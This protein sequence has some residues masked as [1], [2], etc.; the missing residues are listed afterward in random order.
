NTTSVT[1]NGPYTV[2]RGTAST[3]PNAT[4]TLNGPLVLA[5]NPGAFNGSSAV[6]ATFNVGNGTGGTVNYL[7]N[8]PISF[9]AQQTGSSSGFLGSRLNINAGLLTLGTSINQDANVIATA[10]A[11]GTAQLTFQ[12]GATLR[13]T[14]N[15]PTLLT[16]SLGGASTNPLPIMG[17]GAGSATVASGVIDTNGFSTAIN[18]PITTV[19]SATN[20][21]V[22][23]IGGGTLTIAGHNSFG[24]GVSLG[25]GTT[26]NVNNGGV[27]AQAG[28]AASYAS[29]ASFV[30]VSPAAI[31]NLV[32]GQRLT[33]SAGISAGTFIRAI[34]A[35]GNTVTF[36][37][38]TTAAGSNLSTAATSSLGTGT[39]TINGG[40]I[41][42]TSGNPV[43][44]ATN[45]AQ[46]WAGDFAFTGTNDLNMGTGAVTLTG[47]RVVTVGG[48]VLTV[49]GAIGDGGGGFALTKAGAGALALTGA[50]TYTGPTTVNGGTLRGTATVAGPVTVNGG[51]TL[52]PG[53]SVG[54]MT[55]ANGLT[56]TG[57]GQLAFELLNG[58]T[59]TPAAA[60]SGGSTTGT[61]PS[62]TSNSFLDVTGPLT[63]SGGTT[64]DVIGTG[65]TF[66]PAQSYSFQVGQD[67]PSATPFSIN[68]LGQFTFT[69]FNAVPTS[70][71]LNGLATGQV[72]LNFAFTPVPEPGSCCLVVAAAAGLLCAGRRSRGRRPANRSVE[73]E[74]RH[75]S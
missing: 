36:S 67:S 59:P 49:G 34:D 66:D 3:N 21:A 26:L 24:G 13:L 56:T 31:P 69:G 70:A 61:V 51:G 62:P 16:T 42:N 12:N 72:Y 39:F 7:S 45:N 1:V 64:I 74:V 28:I 27:A 53:N 46:T 38:S 5:T 19:V 33:G 29:G 32:L 9:S 30:S 6:N 57:T 48:G 40:T 41:D 23:V 75:A 20:G 44:L 18:T 10:G 73:G 47:N 50:N 2:V 65:V 14:A 25:A 55:L 37:Q 60:D 63:L 35:V 68:S 58:L 15:V 71:S 17:F 43:T 22:S 4:L 52:R 11:T 8:T 54:T